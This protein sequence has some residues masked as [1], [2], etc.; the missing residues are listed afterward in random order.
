MRNE[1]NQF[2]TLFEQV[3]GL[4]ILMGLPNETHSK[5]SDHITVWYSENHNVTSV[6]FGERYNEKVEIMRYSTRDNNYKVGFQIDITDEELNDLLQIVNEEYR[7]AKIAY[8]EMELYKLKEDD[9]V[10]LEQ[11]EVV[12]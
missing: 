11:G 2:K 5:F 8:L 1:L 6:T 10:E 3:R 12:V 9:L 7:K 4:G